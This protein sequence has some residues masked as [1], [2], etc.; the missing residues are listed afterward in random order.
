MFRYLSDPEFDEVRKRATTFEGMTTCAGRMAAGVV[1]GLHGLRCSEV[2]GLIVNDLDAGRGAL[3]V[4]TLKHGEPRDVD[5]KPWIATWLAKLTHGK[6]ASAPLFRTCHGRAPHPNQ[7]G[8]AWRRLSLRWRGREV[9]FHCLR[10]TA[11]QRVWKVTKDIWEVR[12]FL[13]H[14]SLT[15]TLIYVSS[16]GKLRDIMPDR[17]QAETFQPTLFEAG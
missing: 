11:A 17:W 4:D 15:S 7:F 10:H 14:K 5:L 2:C 12:R 3:H 6:P 1:L 8:R 13:G 16:D 9:R